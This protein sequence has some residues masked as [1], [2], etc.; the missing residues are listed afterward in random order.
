MKQYTSISIFFLA[1]LFG[2]SF[3]NFSYSPDNSTKRA[4]F[5][6]SLVDPADLEDHINEAQLNLD[7]LHY[8][9]HP[10]LY[11]EKKRMRGRAIITL[12]ALAAEEEIDINLYDNMKI[13]TLC[14]NGRETK[15]SRSNNHI[16]IDY[17]VEQGDTVVV[18]IAYHGKPKRKGLSAFV[19]GKINGQSLV[20]NLNEPV[21]ASTWFP[22]IDRP[23]DKAMLDMHIT[24]DTT[25]VSVSN[26]NLIAVSQNENRKT[27]H[28][29]TE[30]PISTY[31]IC[32]Y[33]SAYAHFEDSYISEANDTLELH[34]YVLPQYVSQA[35]KDFAKHPKFIEV[36]SELFGEYP[37]MKEKYGVAQFLWQFGAMEHQTITG[38]GSNFI[39]G[40]NYF[41]DLYV[42][43]LAHHWWGNAIAP[44]TWKD[45]WLNEGFATY[46]EALYYEYVDGPEGLRRVMASKF[47]TGFRNTLYNP[48]GD[49]FSETVYDKGAYVLHM[50]R[51]EVGD[52]LF[53]DILKT[54]FETYKYG[55]ASTEDFKTLCEERS[56]KNL[57]TFFKQWIYEGIG[58]LRLVYD[59]TFKEDNEKTDT[60]IT[61]TQIQ[62]SY[63]YYNFPIEVL[64]AFNDGKRVIKRY[65]ITKARDVITEAFD[66]KPVSVIL[67]PYNWLLADIDENK[68]N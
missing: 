25:E 67:D 54:Y 24:N 1:I 10:D 41:E 36:F 45:I 29:K 11:P 19:F 33:S 26:G 35:K 20:Y 21:Y 63:K 55:H 50:L 58:I 65:Y 4:E 31:L 56:G 5:S 14:V 16:F 6:L 64:Y 52:S 43:E 32:L 44:A 13:D 27:Y 15:Y 61:L 34:Y 37:F 8:E 42:H 23:S 38:V 66:E 60:H 18:K 30:Y 53:F 39:R 7:V 57:D 40:D 62:K 51:F 68:A 22:C 48:N 59:T 46:S 2:Y 3:N 12:T 28:W 47:N 17:A 9:L 49:L